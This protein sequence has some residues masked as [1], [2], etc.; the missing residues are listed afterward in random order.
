MKLILLKEK[1]TN[2]SWS[3]PESD[4]S[5][6]AYCS[7]CLMNWNSSGEEKVKSKC[8][9]PIRKEPGGP[10]YKAALRNAASRISQVKGAPAEEKAKAKKRLASL[11]KQAGIGTDTD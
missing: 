3:T 5:A 8:A 6:S 11:K 10:I 7:V 9:L 4:L 2:A 1:F